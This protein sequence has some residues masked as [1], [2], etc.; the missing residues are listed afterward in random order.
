VTSKTDVRTQPPIG[1]DEAMEITK[2]EHDRFTELL[3]SL[4]DGDWQKGTDCVLWDVRGVT[5]HVIGL[6]EMVASIK[7]A[8]HQVKLGKPIFKEK[9][10]V[11]WIDGANEVQVRERYDLTDAELRERWEKASTKAL[12]RRSKLPK[13]IRNRRLLEMPPPV[14]KVPISYLSDIGLTRDVWMHRVDISVAL[15][16]EMDIDA[17]HDGRLISDMVAEWA[18][19]H[20]EPFTMTLTG[21]AGG[22][23]LSG[24]G[25]E[26]IELDAVDF[27][28]IISGRAEGTGVLTHPLPL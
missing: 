23:F 4:H 27:C 15:G 6:A 21:P 7:E 10:G 3:S 14:G 11:H 20:N 2:T 24:N 22:V 18:R 13:I 17:A 9:G 16:R 8:G 25:G 12:R 26:T 5:C 19:T 28:R 1:H